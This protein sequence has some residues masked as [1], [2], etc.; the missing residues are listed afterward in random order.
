M[1]QHFLQLYADFI[2]KV[3]VNVRPRQNFIVPPGHDVGLLPCLRP[4]GC[5][6][7]VQDRRCP[8]GR[9]TSCPPEYGNG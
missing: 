1:N 6:G 7:G 5:R 2:V 8:L 9:T 3:G 4:A